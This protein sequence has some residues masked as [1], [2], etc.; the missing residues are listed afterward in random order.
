ML[1]YLGPWTLSI[2]I[3]FLLIWCIVFVIGHC[4]NYVELPHYNV[5]E[6]EIDDDALLI[7]TRWCGS[8]ML[9]F[10]WLVILLI[11]RAATMYCDIIDTTHVH[12]FDVAN[13]CSQPPG[14]VS[15]SDYYVCMESVNVNCQLPYS[16]ASGS[17]SND[18]L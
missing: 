11:T 16:L 8:K 5:N 15:K 2:V 17:T 18:G 3:C 6:D 1:P 9:Y 10:M 13:C 4:P 12:Y 7:E 14:V